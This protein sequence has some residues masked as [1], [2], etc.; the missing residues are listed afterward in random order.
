MAKFFNR[1][2][3]AITSTGTGSVTC[4]TALA[5]FQSLADAS[6]A[7]AD[8]V[9]YTII[10]GNSY[11]SGTGTVTLSGST[12]SISRGP[13]VS[14]ESNNSA[15]D[16]TASAHLF[17]TMLAQDVKQVLSDLDDVST[18][19]PA[20]GYNLAWNASSSLWTPSPPPDAAASV[21]TL[22]D[23]QAISNPATG[24]LC[25]VAANSSIYIFNG[26]G[27][28][29][30]AMVNESPSAISGISPN[31]TLQ[32]DGTP[33]VITAVSTD[34]EGKPLS[35]SSSITSGSLNGTTITNVDN[36]F[37][38]TPHSSNSTTFQVTFS[39]TDNVNGAVSTTGSF[40]LSFNVT[41]SKYNVLLAKAIGTGS[42]QVFDDA[43]TSNHT[44]T[45]NG[46]AI[47][48]TF[49]PYRHGGYS[50]GFTNPGADDNNIKFNN[51]SGSG[52]VAAS[53]EFCV[54][55]WV[56]FTVVSSPQGSANSRIFVSN[57]SGGN[58]S[59]NLQL[60][61]EQSGSYL[62]A[63]ALYSNG[64]IYQASSASE[65]INDGEW[66]H[67]AVTR[68][69]SNNLRWFVDG[70][71][72]TTIASNTT[73][74]QFEETRLGK[75]DGYTGQTSFT[76]VMG[77]TRVVIGSPV[78]QSAFT[79][80]TF[81]LTA[82]TNTYLLVGGLP[83]I[84]DESSNNF[85]IHAGTF[86]GGTNGRL[87]SKLPISLF[88]NAGYQKVDFG[89]SVALDGTGDYL[90]VSNFVDLGTDSW[91]I[92]GF[93]YFNL[94]TT[95]AHHGLFTVGRDNGSLAVDI[96]EASGVWKVRV[97]ENSVSELVASNTVLPLGEVWTHI[98][99][100][101]TAADSTIRIYINGNLD[102][103]TG[104]KS[105][106]WTF[107][108]K[109]FHLGARYFGSSVQ[110]PVSG[111]VQGFRVTKGVVRYTANFTPPTSPI[112]ADSDTNFLLD[113]NPSIIDSSQASDLKLFGDA[114][115]DATVV[116]FSGT[117]SIALDGT[118]D[119]LQTTLSEQI[120]ISQFTVE[121]WVRMSTVGGPEG[122]FHLGAS[123]FPGN[124]DGLG[125]YT[126]S[127][128]YSYNWGFFC[129]GASVN[130]STAPS[131][132]V[133][134]HLALVRDSNNLVTMYLDGN[135]LVTSTQSGSISGDILTIGG[136]YNSSYTWN[137]NI[138]DFRITKGLARYTSNFTP[139]TSSL[140][141]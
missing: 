2:K 75:R 99:I 119:Y 107:T 32:N 40:G 53:G 57:G 66:H 91:T 102:S 63:V 36:V 126:R 60:F 106:A 110:I 48:S 38:I 35:W 68:D 100:T 98:A 41:N 131:A 81:P 16:V 20:D 8:V 111:Y 50:L 125:I 46:D 112:S 105:S 95:I 43:S 124:V 85:S 78:Y 49:S 18:A 29:K 24:A 11:E 1:V 122:V 120:L 130:S 54:E 103:N 88:D 9:R 31:Y 21:N 33:T 93:Y 133:W 140:L 23:M 94:T 79:P 87:P 15:I 128:T 27:W 136:Y 37:T 104:T 109:T 73:T 44:I 114:A 92:E 13:S 116:K 65:V 141:G 59:D 7:N 76:G 132:G 86:S 26:T 14:S 51:T 6:V 135:S 25:L 39:V 12:Y 138:Q 4:G 80:P 52:A 30:I 45:A 71:L 34:P 113:P 118:G 3:V 19:T 89:T 42:N 70:I 72:I 22:A 101:Y 47:G 58:A 74:F 97:M 56:K 123:A 115:T 82:I 10:D 64:Y 83:Y 121:G 17:L 55:T 77:D 69:S 108:E 62:G 84:K 90:S 5:G 28:Y 61:I 129:N 67:L 117:K 137:G 134:Y 127:S 96:K 139:P